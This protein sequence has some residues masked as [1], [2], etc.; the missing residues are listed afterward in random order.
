MRARADSRLNGPGGAGVANESKHKMNI[1]RLAGQLSLLRPNLVACNERYNQTEGF[2]TALGAVTSEV[3][4]N[5]AGSLALERAV[6][7]GEG[8][9]YLAGMK[10]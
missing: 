6:M 2:D 8:Y 5:G 3:A 10:P 1:N 4:R 7:T 9:T